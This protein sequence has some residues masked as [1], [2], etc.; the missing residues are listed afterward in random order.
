MHYVD[1]GH[2]EPVVLLH[3][4]GSSVEDFACSG[5]IKMAASHHRV[6]AF[7]RPGFG[8]SER[9]RTTAWTHLA[10]ADLIFRAMAKIGIVRATV[11]GHSWGCS[12]ALALAERH[13]RA[14]KA[15]VLASGYYFPSMRSDVFTM[16]PPAI[17]VVGDIFRYT[18]SP[19]TGRLMWP[20]FLAKVFGPEDVPDKFGGF[21]KELALRP[22]Q[23]RAS[24]ADSALMIPDAMEAAP[25]YAGIV[26]PT[27][28]ITGMEDRIVDPLAQSVRLRGV[29]PNAV[30]RRIPGAG[31]MIHQTATQ[32]V[33]TAID[34]ASDM[35]L[36]RPSEIDAEA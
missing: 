10:Q 12:V 2:G 23:I 5:L 27:V 34:E 8:Y 19:M 28:I 26:T 20:A 25:R 21:S 4:N 16:S 3:G 11:L 9:P 15:L 13:P 24:A 30:L 17:P 22:S 36:R 31:H 18:L 29:L 35:H 7:D 14:A 32:A 33:M 1:R 6:V